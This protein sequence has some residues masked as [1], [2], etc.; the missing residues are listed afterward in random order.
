MPEELYGSAFFISTVN[1]LLIFHPN[2]CQR[3]L[4]LPYTSGKSLRLQFEDN[5]NCRI[6]M[7]RHGRGRCRNE[8]CNIARCPRCILEDDSGRKI[9]MGALCIVAFFFFR[10]REPTERTVRAYIGEDENVPAARLWANVGASET[11]DPKRHIVPG[12]DTAWV[13]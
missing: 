3:C 9:A 12:K 8:D 10:R 6:R 13:V 2:G 7:A 11:P 4:I 5:L 1:I